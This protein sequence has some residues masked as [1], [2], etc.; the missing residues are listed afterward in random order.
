MLVV[1]GNPLDVP[2]RVSADLER[3]LRAQELA[4]RFAEDFDGSAD[5]LHAIR[6][7]YAMVPVIESMLAMR[8]T[9]RPDDYLK[10]ELDALW[11]ACKSAWRDL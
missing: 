11:E 2:C 5:H 8:L 7:P 6:V 3:H 1:M 4:E 9:M 10:P